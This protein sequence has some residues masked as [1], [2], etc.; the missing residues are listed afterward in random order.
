[1]TPQEIFDTVVAHL[2]RQGRRAVTGVYNGC[3]YRT[4]DGLRCAVGCLISDE[5]YKPEME[6]VAV[7]NLV[8]DFPDLP[9]WMREHA[10]LLSELQGFHDNPTSWAEQGFSPLGEKRLERLADRWN[11]HYVR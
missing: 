9:G 7:G 2:R 8:E 6:G 5:L 11:L 3:A 4:S 10:D 1:M